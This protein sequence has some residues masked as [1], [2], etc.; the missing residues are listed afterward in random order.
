MQHGDEREDQ[1]IADRDEQEIPVRI[2][3]RADGGR[4]ELRE[5]RDRRPDRGLPACLGLA[6][7]V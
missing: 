4:R 2:Q 3:A 5:T 6:R 1:A 7:F